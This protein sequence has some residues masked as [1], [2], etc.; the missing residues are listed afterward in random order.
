VEAWRALSVNRVTVLIPVT[1]TSAP[2]TCRIDSCSSP[3]VTGVSRS[4]RGPVNCTV[5][6]RPGT[7][8]CAY[9]PVGVAFQPAPRASEPPHLDQGLVRRDLRVRAGKVEAGELPDRA[10]ASVASDQPAAT[11]PAVA[12]RNGDSLVAGL[13]AG[14]LD[15]PAHL[16][17]QLGGALG[18]HALDL[19]LVDEAD[20]I[21]GAVQRLDEDG[22]QLLPAQRGPVPRPAA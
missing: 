15:A 8:P 9:T 2:V 7:G 10:P 6:M 13:E 4:A 21:G 11:D 16:D 3:I 14:Q 20:E 22:V 19:L 1:V 5:R 18:E 17:P 12:R